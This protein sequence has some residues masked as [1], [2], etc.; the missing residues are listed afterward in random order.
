MRTLDC[1]NKKENGD[2]LL[3]TG[4]FN[5]NKNPTPSVVL[6]PFVL[7]LKDSQEERSNKREAWNK[8][9]MNLRK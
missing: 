1:K 4:S 2:R 9:K 7:I 6:F 8:K 5:P 3:I